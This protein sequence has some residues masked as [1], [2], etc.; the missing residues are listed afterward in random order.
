MENIHIGKIIKNELNRQGRSNIWFAHAINRSES[1]CYYIFKQKNID[2]ELLKTISQA[3]NYD[4][5]QVL[6]DD[7]NAS[8]TTK[9]L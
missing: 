5:F 6:S 2:I 3:L 7:F 1:S 9:S 4:F 8:N